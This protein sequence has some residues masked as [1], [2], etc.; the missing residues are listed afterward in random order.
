LPLKVGETLHE[1]FIGRAV[2]FQN[3]PPRKTRLISGIAPCMNTNDQPSDGRSSSPVSVF[4]HK[5][6]EELGPFTLE[7]ALA[8]ERCGEIS[9]A[10]LAWVE[11][12]S[13]WGAFSALKATLCARPRAASRRRNTVVRDSLIGAVCVVSVVC[14][15]VFGRTHRSE[16]G[17]NMPATVP[18]AAGTSPRA[19]STAVSGQS[20]SEAAKRPKAESATAPVVASEQKEPRELSPLER[21]MEI[22]RRFSRDSIEGCIKEGMHYPELTSAYLKEM[23]SLRYRLDERDA[24]YAVGFIVLEAREA[25]GLLEPLSPQA[26]SSMKDHVA[27]FIISG[28]TPYFRTY[29]SML[30]APRDPNDLPEDSKAAKAMILQ[31]LRDYCAK[32]SRTCEKSFFVAWGINRPK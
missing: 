11:G 19:E 14:L 17:S 3:T 22:K 8:K 23:S 31:G 7:E 15:F 9:S 20:S 30:E 10:D 32:A 12:Q 24:Q 13:E 28:E 5:N 6:G 26:R 1:R 4:V 18:A 16:K 25:A 29:K 27:Y 21:A 2:L